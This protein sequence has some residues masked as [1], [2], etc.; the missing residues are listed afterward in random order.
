MPKIIFIEHSGSLR[1]VDADIGE[2][3]MEVAMN[4]LVPGIVADCGGSCTCGTCH[5]YVG[6]QWVGVVG[7]AG[8]DERELLEGVMEPAENSRLSCQI[9]VTEEMEGAEFYLPASQY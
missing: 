5:T 7:Q 9:I 6:S 4:N 1:E 3:V 2:T 8:D